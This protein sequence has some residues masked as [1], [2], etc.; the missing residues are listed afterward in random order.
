MDLQSHFLVSA[1]L[2]RPIV[3]P[4][5]VQVMLRHDDRVLF[6]V[7]AD[8]IALFN[9]Q[10]A[11]STMV[12]VVSQ[13]NIVHRYQAILGKNGQIGTGPKRALDRSKIF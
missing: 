4:R 2:V 9:P 3:A 11:I 7:R 12:V 8:S 1:L 13:L 10:S 5:S 6:A